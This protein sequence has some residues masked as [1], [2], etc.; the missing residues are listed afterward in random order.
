MDTGACPITAPCRSFAYALTQVSAPG[1][2]IALDTAGYGTA[3]ITQSVT[4]VAAPGAT[5]FVAASSGTAI[6]I[7]AALTDVVTLRGL[8]LTSTGANYG[9]DFPSGVSANIENTVVN[10][11]NVGIRMVR[12][13][14]TSKPALQVINATVR[15]NNIGLAA[16]DFGAGSPAGGPPNNICYVTI[17]GSFFFESPSD[18]LAAEDNSRVAVSDSVFTTSIY[19]V[20]AAGSADYS[21]SEVNLDRCTISQNFDGV[22]AGDSVPSAVVHGRVR[23]A[24]CLIT[25]N[26]F[27]LVN[28]L[29]GASFSRISNAEYTNTLEANGTDGSF[30]G[31]YSAK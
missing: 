18:G 6:A 19:G 30:T 8:A 28:F 15:N 14:D 7:N 23:L 24:N 31:T 22:V 13:G 9:I 1:E 29:D 25:G 26:T 17:V 3:N 20:W 4:I 10:G 16:A 12:T 2:L 11:F 21:Y 27:G 5:A